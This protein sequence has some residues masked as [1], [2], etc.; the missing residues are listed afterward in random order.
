MVHATNQ[1]GSM[2]DTVTMVTITVRVDGMVV[3]VVAKCRIN[4]TTI[5]KHA[6]A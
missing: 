2:M 1:L 4:S 5:V 6:N 3:T